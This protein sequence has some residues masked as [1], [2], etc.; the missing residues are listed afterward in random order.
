[1]EAS[2]AA[3][4]ATNLLDNVVTDKDIAVIAQD[5]LQTWEELPPFLELTNAEKEAIRRTHREDYDEQKKAFLQRW[6]KQ[7]GR[8]ATYRVLIKAARES[9]NEKLAN[10]I[11]D[12]LRRS[13]S[14]L[15]LFSWMI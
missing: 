13:R 9:R 7:R 3:P 1:M 8:G 15:A 5:Y 6:K 11:E 14:K 4:V 12:M 10:D 2:D